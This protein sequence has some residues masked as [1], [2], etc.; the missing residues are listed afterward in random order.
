M[1]VSEL[2]R[3]SR[4][5]LKHKRGK[6]MLLCLLPFGAE[7]AFRSAEAAVCCLVLYFGSAV[8]AELFTG[9]S[10]E[11]AVCTAVCGVLRIVFCPPLLYGV[12]RKLVMLS[13]GKTSPAMTDLL[14]DLRFVRRSIT[15]ELWCRAI[16]IA[17][18]VPVIVSG[19]A[20]CRIASNGGGEDALFGLLV[21]G[22]GTL[23]L[24]VLWL[25]V[26][27]SLT[28]VPFLTVMDVRRSTLSTALYS[29]RFLSGRKSLLVRLMAVYALPVLSLAGLPFFLP[30]LMT[31]FTLCLSIFLLEDQNGGRIKLLRI[32][33]TGGIH[34][35]DTA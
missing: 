23:L 31:A 32:A 10:P 6:V 5:L 7:L 24:A 22:A 33:G 27:L 20:F 25:S 8:P 14:T 30:E 12:I 3:Y 13:G 35:R 2:V 18:A 4:K 21:T 16:G 28:A 15:A 29:L 34:E 26:R 17:A 9:G 1:R 19:G 11:L